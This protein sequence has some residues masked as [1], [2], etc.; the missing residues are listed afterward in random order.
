MSKLLYVYLLNTWNICCGNRL[1][2]KIYTPN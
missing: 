2:F 1:C